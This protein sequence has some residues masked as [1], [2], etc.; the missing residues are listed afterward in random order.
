ML[1][2]YYSH[3]VRMGPVMPPQRRQ[4]MD[5]WTI[6][7][8]AAI[9]LTTGWLRWIPADRWNRQAD[10]DRHGG[11]LRS[12][13][14]AAPTERHPHS[15]RRA[16]PELR[17]TRSVI[18]RSLNGKRAEPPIRQWASCSWPE[19]ASGIVAVLILCACEGTTQPP[20][21]VAFESQQRDVAQATAAD[22][23]SCR[24]FS[25]APEYSGMVDLTLSGQQRVRLSDPLWIPSTVEG[26]CN[27]PRVRLEDDHPTFAVEPSGWKK[28][29]WYLYYENQGG[30]P[31]PGLDDFPR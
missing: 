22:P 31:G 16:Q 9:L 15:A 28:N 4:I 29:L 8:V 20:F 7:I 23:D 18:S 25:E 2:F 17:V 11:R 27:E 19:R 5:A 26:H 24:F 10:Q 13:R 30:P 14:A 6:L 3:L 1:G 12:S 21:P